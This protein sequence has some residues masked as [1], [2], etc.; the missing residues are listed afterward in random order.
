M[1]R[2]RYGFATVKHGR[3]LYAFGGYDADDESLS[4][5]KILDVDPMEFEE[6]RS[7][8]SNQY[9]CAAVQIDDSRIL[10]LEGHD[11]RVYYKHVSSDVIHIHNGISLSQMKE[12]R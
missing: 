6:G 11:D 3:K 9:G 4:L 12:R 7:M 5:T 10:V 2:A 1:R 8:M